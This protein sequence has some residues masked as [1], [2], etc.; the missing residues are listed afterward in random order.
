MQSSRPLLTAR[1]RP[2]TMLRRM[3]IWYGCWMLSSNLRMANHVVVGG[4]LANPSALAIERQE[5]I[6]RAHMH[7]HAP[8]PT[9]TPTSTPTPH[10]HTPAPKHTRTHTHT[11]TPT[12]THTHTHTPNP[13]A[14]GHLLAVVCRHDPDQRQSLFRCRARPRKRLRRCARGPRGKPTHLDTTQT[15]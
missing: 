3:P 4:W 11:H 5:S 12:H 2:N 6:F 15:K 14:H 1:P 9:P 10:Q 8:T 7:I 13:P